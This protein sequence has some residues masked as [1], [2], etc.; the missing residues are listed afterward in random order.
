MKK[1]FK[2]TLKRK[3]EIGSVIVSLVAFAIS[4]FLLLT[5]AIPQFLSMSALLLSCVFTCVSCGL[6]SLDMKESS[7]AQNTQNTNYNVKEFQNEK[8]NNKQLTTENI[9]ENTQSKNNEKEKEL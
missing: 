6:L 9:V 1:E 2:N 7:K 4:F 8:T 3:I 5:Y